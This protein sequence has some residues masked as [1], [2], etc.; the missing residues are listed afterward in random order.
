MNS[1]NGLSRRAFLGRAAVIGAGVQIVPSRL[2]FGGP[3]APSNIITRAVIGTGGMGMGHVTAYPQTLAVCDV[4]RAHLAQQQQR[5]VTGTHA[6]AERN[7]STRVRV[8]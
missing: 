6:G 4:D 5:D 3:E 7:E 8:A 2:V 1:Q